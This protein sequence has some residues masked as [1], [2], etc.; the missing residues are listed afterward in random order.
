MTIVHTYNHQEPSAVV[1]LTHD[2]LWIEM[3]R[4]VRRQ[5]LSRVHPG[6]NK[7]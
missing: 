5:L 3:L 7:Q 6:F 1:A 4:M 2:S